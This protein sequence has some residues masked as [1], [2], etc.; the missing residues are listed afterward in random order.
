MARWDPQ[1]DQSSAGF[2]KLRGSGLQGA[3][4]AQGGP[5]RLGGSG[6][7]EDAGHALVGNS[8]DLGTASVSKFGYEGKVKFVRKDFQVQQFGEFST[9]LWGVFSMFVLLSADVLGR[10]LDELM[11]KSFHQAHWSA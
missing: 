11:A 5:E 4:D 1:F 10:K 2:P 9:F 7:W 6:G 3:L 8:L